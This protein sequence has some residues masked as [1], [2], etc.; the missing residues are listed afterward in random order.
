MA[1]TDIQ[2]VRIEIADNDP[3]MP[4]L[5]DE[6]IEYFIEKNEGSLR[7]AILECARCV[8]FRISSQT[9]E[10]VDVLEVRGSDYFNQYKQALEMLIKNPEYGSVSFAQ[11]Y[12]GGISISDIQSN[13]SNLDNNTVKVEKSIPVDNSGYNLNNDSPFQIILDSPFD[14]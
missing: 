5:T 12:A 6:E 7:K 1:F 10:R 3:A 9:F 14:L 13:I 8:L 2:K 4:I 11:A